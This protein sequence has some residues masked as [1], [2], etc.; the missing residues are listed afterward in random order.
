MSCCA[1]RIGKVCYGMK[2]ISSLLWCAE[3]NYKLVLFK[4]KT[5]EIKWLAYLPCNQ[6]AASLMPVML[7]IFTIVNHVLTKANHLIKA[8]CPRH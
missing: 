4:A 1:K 2:N 5:P 8:H 6:E 3:E 7:V